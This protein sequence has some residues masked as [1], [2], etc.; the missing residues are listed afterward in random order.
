[1]SEEYL[2]THFDLP[3][4]M[5]FVSVL[6][7]PPGYQTDFT[8]IGDHINFITS[9][10]LILSLG[11]ETQTFG[12]GSAVFLPHGLRHRV[13]SPTG[14]AQIGM[15][16]DPSMS[17]ARGVTQLLIEAFGGRPERMMPG[18]THETY[19]ALKQL[20]LEEGS[21][22]RLRLINLYEGILWECL[23]IR[24]RK[25]APFRERLTRALAGTD[26]CRLNVGMLAERLHY[27]KGHTDRLFK[28]YLGITA[29]EYLSGLRL[30]A[31]MAL[32]RETD[33]SLAEIAANTGFCDASHFINTFKKHYG[34]TP[35]RFRGCRGGHFGP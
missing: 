31:A 20:M 34:V 29:A 2:A 6:T 7:R 9:G 1:M 35:A 12:A 27:S 8:H 22:P 30:R 23:D 28:Q 5:R 33:R 18:V 4:P 3:A 16:L 24:Q 14:Y 32:L 10:A 15:E 13:E 19:L 17:D 11:G 21:L 25:N 26:P